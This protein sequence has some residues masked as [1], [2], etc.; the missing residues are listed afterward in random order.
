MD[1]SRILKKSPEKKRIDDET[2]GIVFQTH[3]ENLLKKKDPGLIKRFEECAKK[4]SKW[5]MNNAADAAHETAYDIWYLNK[6]ANS[7]FDHNFPDEDDL[8]NNFCEG[9]YD[10]DGNI[11]VSTNQVIDSC[12][13]MDVEEQD[14][15]PELLT[16]NI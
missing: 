2:D 15:I 13:D 11:S 8:I 4:S 3:L 9:D 1:Y 12:L 7:S 6:K 14:I 5:L 16:C 10:V